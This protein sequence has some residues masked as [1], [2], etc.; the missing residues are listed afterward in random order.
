MGSEACDVIVIM[1]NEIIN[2]IIREKIPCFFISP[3]LDDAALSAGG[4]IAYLSQH[5][6]V[7]V[8]D[9]FTEASPKPYT[10]SAKAFLRQCGYADDADAL[11]DARRKE[12]LCAYGTIGITPRNLGFVDALWRRL[13]VVSAVHRALSHVLP[14]F[15]FIYPTFR[16]HVAGGH[17]SRHDR[18][19][20]KKIGGEL[21][22]IIGEHER[23]YIFCP[24]AVKTHVDHV[25]VRDVC[26]K[27]FQHV[28]VWS[29]FPYCLVNGITPEKVGAFARVLFTW[30]D[31][32]DEKKRMVSEYK[33]QLQG[34]FPTG[35][36]PLISEVYYSPQQQGTQR[37]TSGDKSHMNND[38]KKQLSITIGIP[39]RYGGIDLVPT[40]ES[41]RASIGVVI[42]RL[43]VVADRTPIPP[44]IKNRLRELGVELVWNDKEGTWVKKIK[45]MLAMCTTDIF[46][47]TQDD[48][49]FE[50][51]TVAEIAKA[52]E[53]GEHV[54][55]VSSAILPLVAKT[56]FESILSVGVR[57]S[58]RIASFWNGGDNYLSASGRCLSFRT[59]FMEKF[60]IP[61]Q[62]INAD[63][64]LYFKN[65]ELGGVMRHASQSIVCIDQP[66]TLRE[67]LGPSSR[68]QI[69]K[70][71]LSRYFKNDISAEY[72]IPLYVGV[73]AVFAEFLRRPFR[74]LA[75]VGVFA[76]TRA[77]RL[78]ITKIAN[79]FWNRGKEADSVG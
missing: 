24:L 9:V 77:R 19:L 16:V 31:N 66:K 4:L 46:I 7:E 20:A 71:E 70:T 32:M 8:I 48:V 60:E 61:E 59:K 75:Y 3:H 73:R 69:S 33:S 74:T 54:T 40:I 5:T 2:N 35:G 18:E 13:P 76:Y 50:P 14:E 53:E 22:K 63:A 68:Y 65:K 56:F 12:D 67:Q 45:Q 29:D 11:F 44:E 25:L 72:R 1:N 17:V 42:D 34:L 15:S 30:E 21:Q 55:M 62:I 78:P 38:A 41:V 47:T 10:L 64:F 58:G 23:Y 36:I 43:L 37:K 27:N 51:N 79:P 6:H 39:T 57:V 26:L 28:I 52:F 49:I